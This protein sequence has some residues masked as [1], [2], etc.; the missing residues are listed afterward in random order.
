MKNQTQGA[1]ISIAMACEGSLDT[2]T[3]LQEW[4]NLEKANCQMLWIT[5]GWKRSVKCL[6]KKEP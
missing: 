1:E 2:D 3:F 5:V 6:Y 4:M